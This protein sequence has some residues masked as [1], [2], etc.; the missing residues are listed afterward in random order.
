MDGRNCTFVNFLV[1]C[2][3][4]IVFLKSLDASDK[5]KMAETLALML[6]NVV[7]EVGVEN[8]VQIITDNAATYVVV[9]RISQEKHNTLFWSLCAAHVIGLFEDTGKWDSVKPA[10]EEARKIRKYI[11]NHPWVLC[12]MRET[13]LKTKSWL[14]LRLQ[15]LQQFF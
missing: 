10:V 14:D 9:G 5:I 6:E 8:V 12:L 4:Q 2:K 13:S 11:Y 1:S 7:M 15:N 3:D